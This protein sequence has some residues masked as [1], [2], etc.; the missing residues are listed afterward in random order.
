MDRENRDAGVARYSSTNSFLMEDI[1]KGEEL[2]PR[3]QR[4]AYLDTWV[5][6][7]LAAFNL[8]ADC[9]KKMYFARS[10]GRFLITVKIW[11]RQVYH[12][13]FPVCTS[14]HAPG[15][16]AIVTSSES[17][18]LWLSSFSNA[19]VFFPD[20]QK[21]NIRK[22]L[23]LIALEIPPLSIFVGHGHLQH[24]GAE[25]RGS[26]CPRYHIYLTPEDL[27][28]PE[29][30]V[31]AYA[32]P[33]EALEQTGGIKISNAEKRRR[34]LVQQSRT[35]MISKVFKASKVSK[36]GSVHETSDAQSD[37]DDNNDGDDGD[38]DFIGDEEEMPEQNEVGDIV[39]V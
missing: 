7:L 33:L 17:T 16:F 22:R 4:R 18:R 37:D 9:A 13:D 32:E 23:K 21:E 34:V 3:A 1:E 15:Y 8:D 30:I 6:L 29:E 36:S 2:V 5:G 14:D 31:F 12:N 27:Q 35:S 10:G 25:W 11:I 38:D 28:L 39:D 19:L 24:A 26:H 20:N